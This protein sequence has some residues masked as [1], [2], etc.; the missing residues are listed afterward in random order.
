MPDVG[1]RVARADG[2]V[3]ARSIGVA[4]RAIRFLEMRTTG[5][6]P[7]SE[8]QQ[9]K[10]LWHALLAFGSDAAPPHNDP[11]NDGDDGRRAIRVRPKPHTASSRQQS[12]TQRQST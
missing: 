11:Q 12:L 9:L 3:D 10:Y 5:D 7:E 6:P 2:I 1:A 8:A 4:A